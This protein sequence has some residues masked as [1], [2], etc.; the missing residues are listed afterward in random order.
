MSIENSTGTVAHLNDELRI[1][2]VGGKIVLTQS[3][4]DMEQQDRLAIIQAVRE[5]GAFGNKADPYTEHAFGLLTVNGRRIFWKV[6]YDFSD[7]LR[8]TTAYGDALVIVR[9]LTVMLA[10]EY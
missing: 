5:F 3:I 4:A 1:Y 10:S 6:E 9:V 8:N 2:G 7:Y